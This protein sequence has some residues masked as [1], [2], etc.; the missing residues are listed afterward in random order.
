MPVVVRAKKNDTTLDVI[1]RF[2][3]FVAI[4]NVLDIA[5]GREFHFKPSALKN[6]R[7]NELK[8]QK[9]RAKK[10]SLLNSTRKGK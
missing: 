1:K 3:K 9:R 10:M 2:K 8:R 6:I 5:K 4:A 7:Y